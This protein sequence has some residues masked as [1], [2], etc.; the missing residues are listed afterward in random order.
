M[1]TAI[2]VAKFG[3]HVL[4]LSLLVHFRSGHLGYPA[5]S[6]GVLIRFAA[7]LIRSSS[8]EFAFI[9]SVMSVSAPVGCWG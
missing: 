2:I 7:G 1:M 3:G 9:F 5:G 6:C 8:W 4:F